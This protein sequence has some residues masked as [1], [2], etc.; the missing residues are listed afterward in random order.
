M[1]FWQ[2]FYAFFKI[3]LFTFGGGYAMIPL[4]E[5]EI[6]R[7][8]QWIGEEDMYA[9]ITVAEAT[10]GVIAVNSATYVGYQVRGFWGSVLATLGVIL[11]PMAIICLI[12]VFL[13]QFL[14]NTVIA[15]IFH[16]IRAGVVILIFKAILKIFQKTERN[17]LSFFLMGLTFVLSFVAKINGFYIIIAGIFCSL[18]FTYLEYTPEI[19]SGREEAAAPAA[20][21]RATKRVWT[22][23]LAVV[24]GF[25]GLFLLE[26]FVIHPAVLPRL[27][28]LFSLTGKFF[29]M[30]TVTIGGGY[31][32]IPLMK[33]AFI[34]LLTT[35]FGSEVA[36]EEMMLNFLAISE[37]TPGPFAV[38][39]ATNIG[40]TLLPEAPVFGAVI[41]T[42]GVILPSF[43]IILLIAAVFTKFKDTPFFKQ[44]LA[45]AKAVII[46]L[47][48]ATIVYLFIKNVV[49]DQSFADG[50]FNY[51]ALGIMLLIFGLSFVKIKGKKIPAIPLII[52]SG[53]CGFICYYLVPLI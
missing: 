38:N 51:F 20:K 41:T 22:I 29:V 43:I 16:G 28:F 49:N 47:I 14:D 7:K 42:L 45:K 18:L 37:S 8:K 33:D 23:G 50:A 44:A 17:F 5:D 31:A 24:A 52:I 13:E 19:I 35:H 39:M 32:M 26:I 40:F 48:S 53:L 12:S 9:M 36:A 6:V 27:G 10:P 2:L 11:A 30:G 15:A 4:I 34:P 1:M 3:G 46:G 21:Y 25:I